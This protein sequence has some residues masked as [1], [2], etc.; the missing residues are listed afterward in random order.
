MN[1]PPIIFVLNPAAGSHKVKIDEGIIRLYLNN[2]SSFRFIR[3]EYPGHISEIVKACIPEM[4]AAVVAIGG[5]GTVNETARALTGSGIPM[6]IIPT[7][8][9]NGLARHHK[10]PVNPEKAVNVI[11]RN[12]ITDHDAVLI[13]GMLSFNVSGIGFDA[14]VADLFGRD[15][16]RGFNNYLKWVFREFPGYSEKSFVIEYEGRSVRSTGMLAAIANASQYGNNAV[17]APGSSPFDGVTN[18]TIV[19]RMPGWKLPGFVFKAFAG[20][21]SDSPYVLV[22]KSAS[23]KIVCDEPLPLHIDGESAGKN[24]TFEIK[25]MKKAIRLIIP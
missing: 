22:M 17:I 25:T 20:T 24:T 23:F 12:N 9:G 14:H 6:G 2:K 8:S 13:N 4:P 16:K 7:G 18:I 19:R 5:D 10:I 15:G 11:T 21:V 1:T 3:S